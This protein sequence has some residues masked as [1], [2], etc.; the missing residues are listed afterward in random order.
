MGTKRVLLHRSR[1]T[2]ST[3]CESLTRHAQFYIA[4]RRFPEALR[5]LD[6]ILEIVPNDIDALVEKAAIA[7]AEGDLSRGDASRSSPARC[8]RPDW[9]GTGCLPGH[10]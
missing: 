3:Q 5:K 7:Q 8:R 9:M 6:L 4:M 2:R 1:A 10:P